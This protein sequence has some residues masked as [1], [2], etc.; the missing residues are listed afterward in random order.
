VR[1]VAKQASADVKVLWW[2]ALVIYIDIAVAGWDL[3]SDIVGMA[4]VI[5]GTYRL[6]KLRPSD[7]LGQAGLYLAVLVGALTLLY[8]V[9]A[10]GEI[11]PWA[12]AAGT[13]LAQ[14]GIVM[15]AFYVSRLLASDGLPRLAMRWH[16]TARWHIAA[17]VSFLVF[18]ALALLVNDLDLSPESAEAIFRWGIETSLGLVSFTIAMVLGLIAA[19]SWVRAAWALWKT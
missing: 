12:E 5:W 8:S 18:L 2:G 10:L 1:A 11:F 15:V 19:V 16:R 3:S 14:V 9:P 13:N 7:R 6:H 4:L 17:S